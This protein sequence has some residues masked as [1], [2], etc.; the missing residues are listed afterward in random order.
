M[1]SVIF[2]IIV[3]FYTTI[4]ISLA[5][6]ITITVHHR[7][8][9]KAIV[10]SLSGEKV[11]PI[12]SIL[13]SEEGKFQF[14]LKNNHTG[15]YRFSVNSKVSID[16][17]FDG[18]DVAIETDGSNILDS[19][20]VSKSES[21]TIYY[22]FIKLNRDYKIKSE[23]LQLILT[24]YPK[25]DNYLKISKEKLL[26]VQKEYLYFVNV[27]AQVNPSSFIARYIR[28][29]QLPVIDFE[30]PFNKQLTYFKTHTLENLDFK[31]PE[32]VNSDAFT[33]KT[34][35]YLTYYRNPQ[36]PKEVLEKEF[37][38][39]VDSIL[40]KAKVNTRVYQHIV[41][42]LLDG[43]KKFGYDGVINY[44]VQN[45]VIKDDLCLSENVGN[46]IQRLIDQ[47]K[48]LPVGSIAPN[49]SMTTISGIPFNLYTMTEEKVLL[50][51]YTSR[52]PHCKTILP[53]IREL[54][55]AQMNF[56]VVA[57]SLDTLR[58]EWK[59][60]AENNN[61]NF[62]HI[63]DLQGWDGVVAK[64]YFI[65]ATPTMFLLD[66]KKKIVAKPLTIQALKEKLIL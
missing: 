66:T 23:L 14:I 43:F 59:S 2:F 41:E 64:E 34:I 51:F 63:S 38:S 28:S 62:V 53:Q 33:N 1:K 26:Q 12:D 31:D 18:N 54:Q 56:E 16:F 29:S 24:R 42:Y 11:T 40:N 49:F 13:S 20:R 36:M 5:Q 25:E 10:S 7:N 6:Q 58:E 4:T 32:L 15:I 19:I 17:V 44:I 39:A 27:T 57:I 60:F 55:Q 8:D 3:L 50:V 22:K 46:T 45:F 37:I 47:N 35:E 48:R 65:Y 52:C 61:L 9:S 30:L 21:N